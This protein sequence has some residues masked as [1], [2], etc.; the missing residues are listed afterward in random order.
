MSHVL[1]VIGAGA[2][3][4]CAN[5]SNITDN[6]LKPP[7]VNMMF[8]TSYS[9]EFQKILSVYPGADALVPD[10]AEKSLKSTESI[11]EALQELSD[12]QD[13]RI[14]R[15]FRDIPLYL[16]SLFTKVSR[17]YVRI[18]GGYVRLVKRLMADEPPHQVAF[19]SLN[20][21][22][23]LEQGLRILDNTINFDDIESYIA[24]DRQAVVIKP[25]G[26][27]NWFIETRKSPTTDF[28]NEEVSDDIDIPMRP[29]IIKIEEHPEVP[30]SKD[31][32]PALSAPMAQKS[33]DGIVCP[34]SHINKLVE[35][36]K[37][38]EKALF[39]GTSGL[40]SHILEL[41]GTN[42]PPMRMLHV[43]AMEDGDDVAKR[44]TSKVRTVKPTSVEVFKDG[45][46]SYLSSEG[47][48]R[49]AR[50]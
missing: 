23:L 27:I 19:L 26:S 17:G 33:G 41:I 29:W 24:E 40:D 6:N 30:I 34:Q 1:V 2:S 5:E 45:F 7:T 49:F 13:T 15:H 32:Y 10:L 36:C 11:E 37:E 16:C 50:M 21:D 18:P 25:H 3:L 38:C 20:Y 22:D 42:L 39:I 43:V 48:E 35:C 9:G 14:Q 31:V 46:R 12:H 44:I 8:R 47:F 28:A 4:D